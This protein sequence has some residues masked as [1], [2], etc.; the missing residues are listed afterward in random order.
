MLWTTRMCGY[1]AADAAVSIESG[2][3]PFRD[4]EFYWRR[5]NFFEMTGPAS[6]E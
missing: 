1:F 5:V 3:A 2:G 4:V 6:G